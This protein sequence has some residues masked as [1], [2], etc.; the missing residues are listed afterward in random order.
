MDMSPLPDTDPQE[1][2]EWLDALDGVLEYEGAQ[3]AHYLLER[4]IELSLYTE[5]NLK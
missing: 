3:R 2:Q 1:T 4:L 5:E